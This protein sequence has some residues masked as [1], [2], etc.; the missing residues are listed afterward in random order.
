MLARKLLRAFPTGSLDPYWANVVLLAFNENGAHGSTSFIDQSTSAK[1]LT[2]QGNLAWNNTQKPTGMTTSARS[3]G[4]GD[5]LTTPDSDDFYMPGDFTIEAHV[6]YGIESAAYATVFSQYVNATTM[7]AFFLPSSGDSNAYFQYSGSFKAFA[8]N[9]AANTNYVVGWTRSGNNLKFYVNNA[10]QG[11][12]ADLTGVT[13]VN[14]GVGAQIGALNGGNTLNGFW[15]PLR[16]TKG[17]ARDLTVAQTLPFP[18]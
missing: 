14:Q 9:P 1:A 2:T 5:Y 4:T 18:T 8:W 10:Q 7:T 16:I 6:R 12:T 3:D 15:G 13:I 17:V 11:A